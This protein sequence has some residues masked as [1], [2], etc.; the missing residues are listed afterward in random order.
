[1]LEV[2]SQPLMGGQ[3]AETTEWLCTL[4]VGGGVWA[5][6]WVRQ[7]WGRNARNGKMVGKGCF[8]VKGGEGFYMSCSEIRL[9][10]RQQSGKRALAPGCKAPKCY[11]FSL[12][13]YAYNLAPGQMESTNNKALLSSGTDIAIGSEEL[14]NY[15]VSLPWE[16]HTKA[17]L[18]RI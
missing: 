10:V 6:C 12:P 13:A 16:L 11:K 8:K 3:T 2:S 17:L 14:G 15:R 9:T 4:G 18:Q 5:G 1:M 7:G